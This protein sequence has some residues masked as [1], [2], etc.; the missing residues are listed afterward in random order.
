MNLTFTVYNGGNMPGNATW[1]VD[2]SVSNR[3]KLGTLSPIQDGDA[4]G[5]PGNSKRVEIDGYTSAYGKILGPNQS[6]TF[7]RSFTAPNVT[8]TQTWHLLQENVSWHHSVS[9]TFTATVISPPA[10]TCHIDISPS[11]PQPGDTLDIKATATTS[12]GSGPPVPYSASLV[13]TSLGITKP[14]T[15]TI[16]PT[17]SPP[18]N[19]KVHIVTA[20]NPL[21]IGTYTI[22]FKIT[23]PV[24]QV[25]TNTFSVSNK[26]YHKVYGGDVMAGAGINPSTFSCDFDVDAGIIGWHDSSRGAGAGTQLA[27]M[28]LGLIQSFASGQ[29]RASSQFDY[30]TFANPGVVGDTYGGDMGDL[31]CPANYYQPPSGAS[32]LALSSINIG[33]SDSGERQRSGDLTITGGTIGIGKR[34]TIY[35]DGN[36]K[37]TNNIQYSDSKR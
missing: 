37:I 1:S 34:V 7:T 9:C 3:F 19:R 24:N 35:V 11:N 27:A 4:F 13:S 25:C 33:S 6:S 36:V 18:D 16:D 26:P 21:V 23:S 31:P 17:G 28:A 8:T 5:V 2:P 14:Y 20:S 22:T 32:T 29:T 12:G 15:G 30:L 10:I